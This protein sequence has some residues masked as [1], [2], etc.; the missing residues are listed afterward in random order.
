MRYA[1]IVEGDLQ[2]APNPIVDGA[3]R[4]GNPPE[5]VYLRR[6]YKPVRYTDPPETEPGY[7]AVPGW[8]ET[9]EA[10]VQTWTVDVEPDEITD[11]RAYEIIF[12]EEEP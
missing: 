8:E 3:V 11:E 9:E 4:I 5:D 10:I 12:G 2:Y 6:G 7:L 1:K